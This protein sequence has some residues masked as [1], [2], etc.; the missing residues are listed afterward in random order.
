M[1]QGNFEVAVDEEARERERRQEARID[2]RAF[3]G[4]NPPPFFFTDGDYS[5]ADRWVAQMEKL[6]EFH[7]CDDSVKVRYATFMFRNQAEEWW[8]SIRG[9]L[10]ANGNELLW[11]EFLRIFYGQ[12]FP[13]SE[14][15]K[16]AEEFARL[17]Q[18]TM[19]VAE[20]EAKFRTLSKFASWVALDPREKGKKF[21]RGLKPSIRRLVAL[22]KLEEYAD[23]VDR[24]RVMENEEEERSKMLEGKKQ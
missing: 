15:E 14:Q 11:P 4:L 3:Q 16:R 23:I 7:Q 8:R 9:E 1:V 10:P 20:Y 5:V 12:F 22:R 2:M 6:F 24:A 17:V 19:S 18:G 21:Q 13:S